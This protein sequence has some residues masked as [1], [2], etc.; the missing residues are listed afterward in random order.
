MQEQLRES[1]TIAKVWVQYLIQLGMR[2]PDAECPPADNGHTFDGGV[3][4]C[5]AQGISADHSGCTHEHEM[6]P[7]H[8]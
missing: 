4:K 8:S 3:L 6:R 7:A 5:V 1:R 2:D